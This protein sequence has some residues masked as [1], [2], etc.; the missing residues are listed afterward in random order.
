MK[1][2]EMLFKIRDIISQ[3]ANLRKDLLAAKILNML[4]ENGMALL[5]RHMRGS[6]PI[7]HSCNFSD[8]EPEE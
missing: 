2:S 5:P 1:R 7:T 4:E 3:D 6:G 8:W